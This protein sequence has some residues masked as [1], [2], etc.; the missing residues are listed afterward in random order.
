MET[1]SS[2]RG[3]LT[4]MIH[5]EI[6]MPS[7]IGETSTS[8]SATENSTVLHDPYE[9]WLRSQALSL[10]GRN[11]SLD[12]AKLLWQHVDINTRRPFSLERQASP[13]ARLLGSLRS[14][15]GR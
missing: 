6:A 10:T 1:K 14:V 3:K 8:T 13:L 4:L 2:K 15:G 11:M 7:D 9:T 5:P 12:E